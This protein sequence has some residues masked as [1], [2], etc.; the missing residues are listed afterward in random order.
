MESLT[1]SHFSFNSHYGACQHCHGLGVINSFSESSVINPRLTLSEGAILPWTQHPYYTTLLEAVCQLH[2]IDMSI[3]YQELPR[4]QKDKILYGIPETVMISHVSSGESKGTHKAKYEG[5]IRNLERRFNESEG[6]RM[7]TYFL[8]RIATY[9]E[10][11]P[12]PEC[13]GHRLNEVARSVRIRGKNIGELCELSVQESLDF[14]SHLILSEN[15]KKITELVF[16]NI[17][18]RL[19]F[20][21]GVG[22]SYVTLG[23]QAG[24]LS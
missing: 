15:E 16:K 22:L 9:V 8:K 10:E 14:F 24:T 7:D 23:R 12:C 20:L 4:S 11:T 18:D 3:S 5:V 6:D 17:I 2:S 13:H 21:D 1:L 19:E